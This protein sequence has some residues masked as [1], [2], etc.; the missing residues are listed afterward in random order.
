MKKG[1]LLKVVYSDTPVWAYR[2]TAGAGNNSKFLGNLQ[3][4]EVVMLLQDLEASDPTL[5]RR[6][7]A[8]IWVNHL[9]PVAF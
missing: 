5:S 8:W 3:P 6:G 7:F 4:G 1:E 2:V 9:R